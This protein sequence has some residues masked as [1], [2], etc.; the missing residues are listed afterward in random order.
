M[1]E[2]ERRFTWLPVVVSLLLVGVPCLWAQEEPA[3]AE[4]PSGE[5]P[6]LPTEPEIKAAPL[7]PTSNVETFGGT[8]EGTSEPVTKEEEKKPTSRPSG[9]PPSEY[10]I[11]QGDTLWDICQKLL[12][13]PWYWPKLWALNDYIANPH[14]IYPGNKLT[15]FSGSET[16]PPRLEIVD[17]NTRKS[18]R[19]GEAPK[20]GE[21]DEKEP[22]APQEKTAAAST[23]EAS[24]PTINLPAGREGITV[25]GKKSFSIRLKSLSF[26]SEKEFERQIV[27]EVS[28][29]GETKMQLYQGDRLYLS[30]NKRWRVS[31]GDRFHVVE[32]V[33]NVSDPDALFGEYGEMIRRKAVLRVIAVKKNTVD[34]VIV[35]CEDGVTR[36][37]KIVPYVSPVRELAVHSTKKQIAGKIIDSEDQKVLISN[38]DFVFLDVGRKH[39]VDPGLRLVVVR[40][41]DGIF[42][43]D[44][45]KLPD[46]PYAHL[47][48]VEANEQT[49]TA[50]VLSERDGLAVGDRVRNEAD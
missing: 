46:V 33:K 22:S 32:K 17:E 23:E 11:Q 9:E 42:Q 44:D 4:P 48:V 47:V 18:S 28:H 1:K 20:I 31:V 15:F 41:G 36:G 19:S 29:S 7:P 6:N 8:S 13:N 2:R 3:P 37:D 45:S 12:D 39:G 40:R 38:N 43:G 49:S 5:A 34:A 10:Q 16:A 50:Y 26:L 24:T 27:G 25:L 30:F 14:L 21:V 35:D